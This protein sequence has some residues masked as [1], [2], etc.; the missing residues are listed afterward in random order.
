M[1]A[2]VKTTAKRRSARRRK[3][4]TSAPAALPPPALLLA[5]PP[6]VRVGA[7]KAALNSPAGPGLR[8]EM[9]KQ[10]VR[11][12]SVLIPDVYAR[13]RT[14]VQDCMYFVVLHLSTGRLAPKLV[15]QME[16]PPNTPAEQRLLKLI[17]KVPGLQKLGQVLAR[18]PHLTPAL[19]RALS[20][21]ENGISD[22][23]APEIRELIFAAL[24]PRL[25][26]FDVEV[27]DAIFSEASVSAVVRF[28]WRNPESSERERGV[29]K[30]LKPYVPDCYAED[31]EF[32]AALAKY[33]G[34]KDARYG[35][36]SAGIADTFQ[37]VR[38]LLRHEVDFR[39]EQR[40]LD[41]ARVLYA[42]FPGVRIPRVIR[43]L[44]AP[45]ITAMTE[46][47]GL[48]ITD[49]AAHLSPTGRARAARQVIEAMVA[50]PLFAPAGPVMFHAD[51]HAGNL[52]YDTERGELI[53]LDW[54]LREFLTPNQRRQLAL[55]VVMM[56]LRDPGGIS[57][58]ILALSDSPKT[59]G[60]SRRAQIVHD[61]VAGFLQELP[62]TRLPGAVDAM[63]LLERAGFAGI[64]FPAALV[65]LSKVMFTLDG[66]LHDIGA[67]EVHV[68]SVLASYLLR[69]WVTH[70]TTVGSPLLLSDW[71][72]VELSGVFYGSRIS[73][74][75]A[76]ATL[77]RLAAE[78]ESRAA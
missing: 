17:A 34:R 12:L 37:K 21:L 69:Q 20:Q 5:L 57:E 46:E 29:F 39:G 33:L 1:S 3:P 50:V 60:S 9:G 76:H 58:A 43:P 68:E 23:T 75:W 52:L 32:L 56:L 72:R 26:K 54:A 36:P 78:A 61:L 67:P 19:R 2:A 48:K 70:P 74:Q 71:L 14:L 8:A 59:S 15:E 22:V 53:P 25:Q 35:V 6:A 64:R 47:P 38:R 44:C 10:V 42:S 16:L 30:V 49:A 4:R 65:M 62:V 45:H 27:E 13:W 77:A 41:D 18:D 28:T 73:L 31:M 63:R 24:G 11:Q 40:T 66:V 51:P 55:L 7:V